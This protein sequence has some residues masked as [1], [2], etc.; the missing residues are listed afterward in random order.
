MCRAEALADPCCGSYVRACS[1]PNL[2]PDYNPK[3]FFEFFGV[4]LEGALLQSIREILG[5]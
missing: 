5:F 1:E 3:D 2:R 4:T